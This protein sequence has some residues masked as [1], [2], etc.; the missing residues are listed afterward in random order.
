MIFA[1]ITRLYHCHVHDHI[2]AGMITTY[3]VNP[4]TNDNSGGIYCCRSKI[5]PSAKFNGIC[6]SQTH[7][8][9]CNVDKQKWCVWDATAN[10]KKRC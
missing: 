7:M 2:Q 5:E 9:Q 8:D 1:N 10:R 6:W 3:N 4:S